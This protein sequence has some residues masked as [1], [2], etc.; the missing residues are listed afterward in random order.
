[1]NRALKDMLVWAGTHVPYYQSYFQSMDRIPEE[2]ELD[3]FPLIKKDIYIKNPAQ[4]L[5]ENFDKQSLKYASTSG[6]TMMPLKVV[7]TQKDYYTQLKNMWSYRTS[8]YGIKTNT[9]H[10]NLYFFNERPEISYISS[11][12]IS[13]NINTSKMDIDWFLSHIDFIEDFKPEYIIAYTGGFMRLLAFYENCSRRLPES[14]RHIEFI[15]EPLMNYQ[16]QMV[17]T[18]TTAQLIINYSSTEVLGIAISCKQGH[19]HCIDKNVVVEIMKNGNT[20]GYGQEGDIVLTSIFAKAMP[21]I[22]YQIGDIGILRKGSGCSCGNTNDIIEITKGRVVDYIELYNG[23]R[24]HSVV[25]CNI[26]EDISFVLNNCIFCF[27]IKQVSDS[28]ID[29]Y[30]SFRDSLGFLLPPFKMQFLKKVRNIIH[31]NIFWNFHLVSML[32][33]SGQMKAAHFRNERQ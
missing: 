29:I 5:A 10:L 7:K 33:P 28:Q 13:F 15:G 22:R 23:E 3:D 1:M 19:M 11:N 27:Q 2:M 21:F 30:L 31:A 12:G 8:E 32:E 26:I 9:K 6:T 18:F 4:F 16:L 24:I 14:I 20:C 25:L 17:K